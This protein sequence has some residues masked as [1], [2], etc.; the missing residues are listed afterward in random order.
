MSVSSAM[1][2]MSIQSRAGDEIDLEKLMTDTFK[3]IQGQLN[4][5]HCQ[6]CTLSQIEDRGEGYQYAYPIQRNIEHSI[7]CMTDL[8]KELKSIVKQLKLSPTTPEE[9]EWKLSYDIEFS[10][11]HSK[12]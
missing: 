3:D 6:I 2:G 7:T 8:F 12:K 4:N 5:V 9:R 1:S 11:E 10:N